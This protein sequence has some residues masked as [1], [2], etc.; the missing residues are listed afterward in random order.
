MGTSFTGHLQKTRTVKKCF[1]AATQDHGWLATGVRM[2]RTVWDMK[3][4]RLCIINGDKTEDQ[5]LDVIGT[6]LHN[7]PLNRWTDELAKLEATDEVKALAEEFSRTAQKTVEPKP[8][9][10]LN[11][12]KTYFVAK[13]IMAAEN[14]QGISLNCLGLV[15]DA[16]DSLPALHGLFEA[17]G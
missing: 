9:D 11:A 15:A 17:Q 2:M 13:R 6:T 5:R 4:T 1:T 3:N 7:V 12:A 16:A 14:C 8:Q 10:V